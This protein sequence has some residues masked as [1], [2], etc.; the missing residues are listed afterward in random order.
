M[1]Q[2]VPPRRNSGDVS[3][4]TPSSHAQERGT[5]GVPAL[6]DATS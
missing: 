1:M 2:H 3:L 4:A 5:T 6:S